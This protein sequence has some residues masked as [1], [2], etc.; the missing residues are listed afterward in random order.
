VRPLADAERHRAE[1]RLPV[2]RAVP[3]TAEEE[4][5]LELIGDPAAWSERL[6]ASDN[7]HEQAELL[8][9][10]AGA[11]GLDH[12][13]WRDRHGAVRGATLLEELYDVAGDRRA[14]GAVRLAAA[15]LGKVEPTLSDAAADLFAAQKRI[16]I[17][18]AY[19]EASTVSRPLPQV[20]LLVTIA[21][22]C[23]EDVRDRVL[24][25]ELIIAL[26]DLVREDPDRFAGI[27]TL[28]LGQ[29]TL[30]LASELAHEAGVSQDEGYERLASAAPSEVRRRL[31]RLLQGEERRL[32]E[33]VARQ[34]RLALAEGAAAGDPDRSTGRPVASHEDGAD[35]SGGWWRWRQ[36]EGSL[37]RLPDG[38]AR[39]VWGLLTRCEGLV[40]GDKLERR[41]R[42]D[43]RRL[44]SESTPGELNFAL[45]VEHL[46]HKIPSA[47]YRQVTV[48]AIDELAELFA[49]TP[50]LR[51]RGALVMDVLV[52]HAVREAWLSAGHD[53]AGYER[54]KAAAWGAF[55]DLPPQRTR[56]AV[57]A[58]FAALA[59][60]GDAAA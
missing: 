18:K 7:L 8:A 50:A 3:L 28:R 9:L 59:G 30:L 55:Y 32:G 11:V 47:E 10:L 23:R 4:L 5:S 20:E 51:V 42:L 12:V 29:F 17:G 24:T 27:R 49:A 31:R 54:D 43:S 57:R 46:L 53:P 26:A 35:P 56:A 25:Q 48:E 6:R 22:F 19:S 21:R 1:P 37:A 33:L 58:A 45:R 14:W 16:L 40:I 39:R 34:E 2:R 13:L 44:T 15:L 38:F 41:N 52:G 36:R 60:G